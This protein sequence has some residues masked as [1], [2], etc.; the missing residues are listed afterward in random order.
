MRVTHRVVVWAVCGHVLQ[1]GVLTAAAAGAFAEPAGVA[2]RPLDVDAVVERLIA[3]R[4]RI[5]DR[6]HV[7]IHWTVEPP[8]PPP[9]TGLRATNVSLTT[10]R[11]GPL[12]RT[13][14]VRRYKPEERF[15]GLEAELYTEYF[16]RNG[17]K[18]YHWSTKREP[19][20]GVPG[21]SRCAL[22]IFDRQ[23]TEAAD[24]G[25]N[26]RWM[27][28]YIAP[29]SPHPDS[30]FRSPGF[31]WSVHPGEWDGITCHVLKGVRQG[32]REGI[33]EVW[34][35]PEHG[36]SVIRGTFADDILKIETTIDVQQWKESG[37][38]LPTRVVRRFSDSDSQ[39]IAQQTVT[40][41]VHSLNEPI[42]PAVF[43]LE[44]LPV[45]PGTVVAF[46]P[47]RGGS[48][49]RHVWDGEKVVEQAPEVAGGAEERASGR[50][51]WGV[52]ING[53]FVTLVGVWVIWRA[54]RRTA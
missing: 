29:L 33:A 54:L 32:D 40:Y 31:E 16:I 15:S 39:L 22:A 49:T 19:S 17:P 8:E 14:T 34:V 37:I 36:W 9:V 24:T 27:G 48:L 7:E 53:L 43:T 44:T 11:D 25:R 46:Y 47:P 18:K 30:F 10:W 41:A 21:G 23:N 6:W 13:E 52:L 38:W 51:R 20:E 35:A 3:N 4:S 42:D 5:E 28:W 50:L 1:G 12:Y 26:I 2:E 45:D